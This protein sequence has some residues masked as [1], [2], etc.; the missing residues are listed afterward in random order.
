M[1][2]VRPVWHPPPRC[3]LS[4]WPARVWRS[5][6][7]NAR[8]NRRAGQCD[9]VPGQLQDRQIGHFGVRHRLRIGDALHWGAGGA[10]AI[11]GGRG[12]N[13]IVVLYPR[14]VG[15]SSLQ[16]YNQMGRRDWWGF[17]GPLYARQEGRRIRT[18][19]AKVDRLVGSDRGGD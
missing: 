17:T 11:T 10:P 2:C 12:S 3:S 14:A 4:T 18:V 5:D 15:N 9:D 8:R 19:N 16:L 13:N 7:A 6:R 1:P